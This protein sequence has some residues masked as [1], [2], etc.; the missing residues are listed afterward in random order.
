MI[1]KEMEI[2]NAFMQKG[3]ELALVS[4]D[5][6]DTGFISSLTLNQ[7][8]RKDLIGLA[9][10]LRYIA[11]STAKILE[12][13]SPNFTITQAGMIFQY[14]FDRTVEV[15]YKQY[16]GIDT[17]SVMFNVQEAFDYYEPD[18][19]Y[20]VQQILTNR[21]GNI[22]VLTSKLWEFMEETGVFKTP[23]SIW[24]SNFLSIATTLGIKFAQEIDFN[25]ESELNSFLNRI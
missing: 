3:I 17:D 11:L 4:A 21:V 9:E 2:N 12:K 22:A 6:L 8:D 7:M 19:P 13:Q 1:E 5:N 23:F 10:T 25:D 15:F 20:N 18:V 14:F 16:N 24:F